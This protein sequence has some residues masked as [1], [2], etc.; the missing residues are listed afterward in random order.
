MKTQMARSPAGGGR[1]ELRKAEAGWRWLAAVSDDEH[2]FGEDDDA[3]E[4]DGEVAD[5]AG[6]GRWLSDE[7]RQMA[8]FGLRFRFEE[9]GELAK[10]VSRLRAFIFSVSN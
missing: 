6:C 8:D 7:M 9:E 3:Q 4:A 5:V 2:D 10:M 1:L